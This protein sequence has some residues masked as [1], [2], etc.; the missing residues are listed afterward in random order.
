MRGERPNI[1]VGHAG[2]HLA[3]RR[4]DTWVRPY[5]YDAISNCPCSS[6]YTTVADRP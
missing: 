4:A 3:T 1:I 5:V 2:R 6:V